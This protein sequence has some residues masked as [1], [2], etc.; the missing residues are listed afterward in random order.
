MRRRTPLVTDDVQPEQ[1]T[2]DLRLRILRGIPF[3]AALSDHDIVAVNELVRESGYEA[4]QTIYFTGDRAA[5]WCVVAS[6]KVKLL[7]HAVSGQDVLLDILKPGEF[8]GSLGS[9]DYE[10]YPE[11]AQAHTQCCVLR[12][13]VEDFKTM[14]R[15]YPPVALAVL[16]I[17]AGRLTTA[18]EMVRQLSAYAVEQR[19]AVALLKLAEKLGEEQPSGLLIQVPLSRQDLAALTGATTET[20][21]RVMSQFRE[22]GVIDS[23]RQWVAITDLARLRAIADGV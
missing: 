14:L 16:D 12:I 22:A 15:R 2:T 7:R 9:L 8:F 6:G 20:V 11:T 17:V 1:C 21:S 10:T 23:G 19:V 3:L 5:H 13:A 18:H 4:G